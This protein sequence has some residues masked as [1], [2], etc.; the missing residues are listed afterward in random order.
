MDGDLTVKTRNRVV[1]NRTI[2]VYKGVDNPITIQFKNQDQKPV[3]LSL[4]TLSGYLI[5]LSNNTIISNVPVTI[6]NVVT[7][8]ASITLTEELLDVLTEN[9]YKLAFKALKE[10]L[11][12]FEASV[13]SPVYADDNYGLYQEIN[14]KTGFPGSAV[15]APTYSDNVIDLGTL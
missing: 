12:P 7:G 13:E 14:V 5:S 1:Y 15:Y 6:A 11:D 4:Y 2:D 9:K 10:S 8:T 3:N